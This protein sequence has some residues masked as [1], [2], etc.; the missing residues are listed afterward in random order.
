MNVEDRKIK[1]TFEEEN[2]EVAM[3]AYNTNKILLPDGRILGVTGWLERFPP[4]AQGLTLM[5]D[6]VINQFTILAVLKEKTQE[7]MNNKWKN[8]LFNL[9]LGHGAKDLIKTVKP[10]MAYLLRFGAEAVDLSN[11]NSDKVNGMH[12]A[13]VLRA[14]AEKKNQVKDWDEALEV[15]KKALINQGIEPNEALVGLQ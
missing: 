10:L 7:E 5:V 11:L 4:I 2:Y 6:A 1:F 12:L 9:E 14:T 8:N 15:V 3:E 13:V